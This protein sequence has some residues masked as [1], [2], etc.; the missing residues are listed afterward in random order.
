MKYK[1]LDKISQALTFC[2]LFA[3]VNSCKGQNQN[4]DSCKAH[5]DRAKVKMNSFYKKKETSLLKQALN[6]VEQSLQCPETRH[7]AIE[8]K[9]GLLSTSKQYKTAYEF[10]NSLGVA[11]FKYK[12]EKEMDYN[13]FRA[14]DYESKS[15]TANQKIYLNKAKR[16]VT[17]YIKEENSHTNNLDY[18]AYYY[19]FL[20]M[21]KTGDVQQINSKADS[22]KKKNPSSAA[23]IDG[24]RNVFVN[25]NSKS[26][27]AN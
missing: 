3:L 6:D 2:C 26:T 27:N 23:L 17:K 4:M 24:L 22:L 13:F 5:F 1:L 8:L 9:I 15:D 20:F 16:T 18:N 14:L 11:D 25:D 7:E 12:Y 19:L 21:K 10:I